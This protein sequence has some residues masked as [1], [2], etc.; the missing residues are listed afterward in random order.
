M[1]AWRGAALGRTL[2]PPLICSFMCAAE[3]CVQQA[4][5]A[6]NPAFCNC[7]GCPENG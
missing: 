6:N 7:T 4:A 3:R 5:P 1:Q 2:K